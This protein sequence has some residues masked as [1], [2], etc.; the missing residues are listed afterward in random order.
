MAAYVGHRTPGTGR[1]H[2]PV[3]PDDIRPRLQS[4]LATLADM[5]LA[6]ERTIES[7]RANGTDEVQ[8]REVI[9]LIRKRHQERRAPY[10]SELSELQKRIEAILS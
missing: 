9:N 8:K 10:L 5:D 3:Y 2:Y 4:V 1:H 6:L 7:I